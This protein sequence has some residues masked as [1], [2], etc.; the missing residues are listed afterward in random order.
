MKGQ[1]ADARR[2]YTEKTPKMASPRSSEM[3][4]GG[5]HLRVFD[6]ISEG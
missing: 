1:C 3:S 5:S 6:R 2:K 4:R